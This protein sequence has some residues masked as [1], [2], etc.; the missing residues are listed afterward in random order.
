[1][2]AETLDV[3]D[4]AVEADDF[5]LATVAGAGIDFPDVEGAAENFVDAG[6]EFG[7]EGVDGRGLRVEG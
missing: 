6:F 1:M 5:D 3:I 2:N 7:G 4:G